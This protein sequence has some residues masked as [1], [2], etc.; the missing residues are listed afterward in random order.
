MVLD[1]R[2]TGTTGFRCPNVVRGSVER[3]PLPDG[4]AAS[5][6]VSHVLEHVCDPHAAM[7]EL[8]RVTRGTVHVAYPRRASPGAWLVPGHAWTMRDTG[9]AGPERFE[10]VPLRPGRCNFPTRRGT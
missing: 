2:E 9:R 4:F 6:F 10:F 8:H 1:L 3:I 7:R 5:A